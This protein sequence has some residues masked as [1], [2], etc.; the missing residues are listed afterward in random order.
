MLLSNA[1][2]FSV[3]LAHS[4]SGNDSTKPVRISRPNIGELWFVCYTEN[5][6]HTHKSY[7]HACI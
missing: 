3:L 7:M 4:Q 6:M 5:H 2:R 1:E